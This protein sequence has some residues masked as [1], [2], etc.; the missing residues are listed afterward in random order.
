MLMSSSGES[1]DITREA[2]IQVLEMALG[3]MDDVF[4]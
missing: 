2:S 1:A 4:K 3:F